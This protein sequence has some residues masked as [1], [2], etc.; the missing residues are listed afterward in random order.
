MNTVGFVDAK[1]GSRRSLD[2]W[3]AEHFSNSHRGIDIESDNRRVE[4]TGILPRVLVQRGY[5]PEGRWCR[6]RTSVALRQRDPEHYLSISKRH[7]QFREIQ[8]TQG[9]KILGNGRIPEIF[10]PPTLSFSVLT[11]ASLL[12]SQGQ[13]YRPPCASSGGRKVHDN[14]LLSHDHVA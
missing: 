9:D 13:L 14:R 6:R 8:V 5:S 4:F 2:G 3:L 10:H 12:A 1:I 7:S 11:L